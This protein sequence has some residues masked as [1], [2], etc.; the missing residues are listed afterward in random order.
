MPTKIKDIVNISHLSISV[1]LGKGFGF[2]GKGGIHG[3]C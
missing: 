3:Y 2:G 1:Y